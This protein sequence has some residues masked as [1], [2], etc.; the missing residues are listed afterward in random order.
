MLQRSREPSGSPGQGYPVTAERVLLE[1]LERGVQLW[2]EGDEVRFRAPKGAVDSEL[3]QA[4]Q[5]HKAEIVALL[6]QHRKHALCS[7][8]QRRLWFVD[9]LQPGAAAYNMP[10]PLKLSGRLDVAALAAARDRIAR[11]HESLRTSLGTVEGQPVQVI[12]L[13]CDDRPALPRVDL[14]G[15]RAADRSTEARRLASREAQ[16]PFELGRGPLWRTTLLHLADGEARH[17]RHVLLLTMHH[18]VS[19]GRSHEILQHEL[20]TFYRLFAGN[21]SE[22]TG[23]EA[24]LPELPVQY[25]DFAF[26]QRRQLSGEALE[27]HLDYWRRQLADLP[28]VELPADRPRQ[29]GWSPRGATDFFTLPAAGIE[30]LGRL[31]RE[32]KA[33]SF[34]TLLAVFLELLRRFTGQD[35]LVVGS[36]VANRGTRELEGLIGFFVNNL[37]LRLNLSSDRPG[38]TSRSPNFHDLLKRVRETALEAYSHQEL[39]FE[40]LVEELRPRRDPDRHPLFQI[41]FAAHEGVPESA[42]E[43]SGLTLEPSG[44]ETRTVRFDAE[45]N[46]WP[47]ASTG[48]WVY[49]ADLFDA[50]TIARLSRRLAVLLSAVATEPDRPLA[51][52]PWLPVAERHQLLV[53][54]N[55]TRTGTPSETP[56]HRLFERSALRRP[57]AVA[58]D[59][60]DLKLSYRELDR[61]AERLARRLLA[62]GVTAE[63]PVGLL[64]EPCAEMV[65][66]LLA[67]LEAGGA[68]LPLDPSYPEQRLRDM[69]EDAG[70]ELVL[71]RRGGPRAPAG[72]RGIDLD[73]ELEASGPAGPDRGNRRRD[74]D[75]GA[76][77]YVMYTSGSTGRPKGIGIPHRAIARLALDT[78]YV[79]LRD[80]DRVAQ[81]SNTSFDAATFEIWGA[82]STGACLTGIP[83]DAV[84]LPRRLVGELR[85]RRVSTLFLTT[86]LFN[87]VIREQPDGLRSLRHVLFGGEAVDPERV[88]QALESR[89]PRRSSRR[90]TG[91]RLLHVYGPTESTTFASWQRVRSVARGARGVPIGM[92]LSN[93]ELYVTASG[94]RPAPAG[95][96]GELCVGGDG[97]A[98]GYLGRP[99]KT[100]ASFVPDPFSRTPGGRLYRTGDRVCQTAA[101]AVD[102][103]GRFDHQLKIRGFRI[104]PG[105]I[106]MA[107]GRHPAVREALVLPSPAP[108]DNSSGAERRP[109]RLIAYVVPAGDG[110]APADELRAYLGRK[111]PAFMVPSAFVELPELPLTPGGKV[112]RAALARAAPLGEPE[113]SSAG[114]V[115]PSTPTEEILAG[116]FTQVLGVER[117]GVHDDFFQLGGHSLLATRV[118]SRLR[119]TFRAELP[120]RALFEKPTVAALATAVEH[121]SATP[122]PPLLPVA[123]DRALPLSF[124][125]QRLWFLHQL[126]SERSPYHMP[127]ALGLRGDLDTAALEA[128]FNAL[129][130]RHEALRTAFP[131]IAGRPRQVIASLRRRGLPIVDLSGLASP[132][133][134]T[135]SDRLATEE[136]VRPFDLARGPL[137]RFALLCHTENEHVLLLNLHHVISDGWSHGVLFDELSQ[138]YEAF[139]ERRPSP[140]PALPIQYADF[141]VWQR[142]WLSDGDGDDAEQSPLEAQLDYWRDQLAGAPFLRLPSDRPAPPVMSYRGAQR[143][144]ALSAE[145]T[146]ALRGLSGSSGATLFMTLM[147]AFMS[148][149]GRLTGLDDVVVG[150]P[151][152]NRNRR[153]IERLIG[154]FVNTLALRGDLSGN[155]SFRALLGRIRE[156][157]FSA[158]AHQDLPFEQLVEEL[159][160]E[161]DLSRNPLF[162]VAFMLQNA[163]A[164]DI[165]LAG[166]EVIPEMAPYDRTRYDLEVHLWEAG[167]ALDGFISYSTDLFDPTTMGRLWNHYRTLL[168]A[169]AEGADLS[170]ADLPLLPAAERQ[171]LL[172]EWNDNR[173]DDP[174]PFIFHRRFEARAERQG[175]AVALI[176]DHFVTYRQLDRRANRLA[177]YLRRLGIGPEVR[178]GL[179][180]ERSAE[181]VIALLAILKSGGAY[182]PLDP[183]YPRERL[184]FMLRDAGCA[185][186][187]TRRG[188]TPAEV[189]PSHVRV[190]CL[191]AI[192][193]GIAGESPERPPSAARADNLAYVIYTSG[194]TGLPKG[195][196]IRH[197]GLCHLVAEP[198]LANG[199]GDHVLQF[200]SL[201]FDAS[202]F[203]I[204]ATLGGGATLHLTVDPPAP[205]SPFLDLLRRRRVSKAVV[206]PS[207]LAA[208]P[209][210]TSRRLPA[211][212]CLLVAGEPC[213]VDLAERW[214]EGRRFLNGYGPTEATVCAT[215]GRLDLRRR[216]LPI[217]RANVNT[218][219]QVADSG[220]R[221]LPIATPG[222]LLIGGLGVGRGY[223][224][225]RALTAER[226]VP[227]PF[228]TSPGER[229]YR[230]GDLVHQL[231]DGHLDF[232]GRID[233]QVKVRGFRIELAE[234][235]AALTSH[236]L[237]REAAVVTR[238]D[239]AGDRRQLAA[240]VVQDC[241]A[242]SAELE[243]QDEWQREQVVGWR[244]LFDRAYVERAEDE[245]FNITGWDSS[246]TGR[247]IPAEEMR[248]WVDDTV[249]RLST[250]R[251]EG[252]APGRILE[253]GCGTGLLLH[254][255]APICNHYHGT[256][257]SAPGIAELERQ[258]AERS[259][260]LDHVELSVRLAEDFEGVPEAAYDLVILNSVAQYFSSADHLIEV[261]DGALARV[262]PGGCLFVGDVRSLPLLEAFHTSVE[263][264]KADPELPV[265]TLRQRVERGL[266][267]ENE[268]LLDPAFFEAFRRRHRSVRRLAVYPKSARSGNELTRFR[269]QV[270]LHLGIGDDGDDTANPATWLDWQSEGLTLDSVRRRL[271]ETA[272]AR[273]E[274]ARVPNARVAAAARAARVLRQAE[275]GVTAGDVLREAEPTAAGV[276]P[277]AL[278]ELAEEASY[279]AEL[280]WARHDDEGC[281]DL[282]LRRHD[283]EPAATA[284]PFPKPAAGRPWRDYA[285]DPLQGKFARRA[286]PELRRHLEERLPDFMIPAAFV[287]LE[288]MPHTPSGKVDRQ[289]LP[290]PEAVRPELLTSYLAPR[291][292]AEQTLTEIWSEV[293]G[294]ERVGVDDN[295]FE[296]GGHS[297]LGTQVISR[298]RRSFATQVPLKTLFERPT[299][300]ELAES[301]EAGGRR[302]AAPPLVPAPRD[303]DLPLSF[304]QQRLWFLDQLEP[305]TA[306]YN[307]PSAFHLAGDLDIAA[308]AAAL[309]EIARRHEVLRTAFPT[310]SGRPRQRITPRVPALLDTIDLTALPAETRRLETRRLAGRETRRPFDLARGPLLRAALLRLARREH[311][312]LLTMHHIISDGWSHGV[313]H[314]ELSALYAARGGPAAALPVLPIQYADFAVWQ[315]Q[316]LSGEVLAGELDYWR[317]QLDGLTTLQ[318]PSDRPRPAIPSYLGAAC[319]VRLDADLVGALRALATGAGASQFMTLLAGFMALLRRLSGQRDVVVGS[320]VANR[321]RAE[322]EPLIGF[323]VNTLVLRLPGSGAAGR[324]PDFRELLGQVRDVALAA[325]GHQH[326]SFEKLVEELQPERDLALHPL[327]QVTFDLHNAARDELEL[328][329]LVLSPIAM[330][331]GRARFDMEWNL[332]EEEGGG[333]TAACT[334]STELFDAT[335]AARMAGQFANLLR[336]IA[337]DPEL[338]PARAPLLS[339]AERHQLMAEW[340]DARVASPRASCLHRRFERQARATPDAVALVGWAGGEQLSYRRL[341]ARAE[342]LSRRLLALGAGPESRVALCAE[343]SPEM[344][345][346]LL[347]IW[348]AGAA[349]V[350][351]DPSHPAER[352]AFMLE[353]SGASI[354]LTDDS[355]SSLSAAYRP[356]TVRLDAEPSHDGTRGTSPGRAVAA[357]ATAD[358]L[359]YLIYTSG[360]TGK[361]KGVQITHRTLDNFLDSMARQPGFD[362]RDVLLAVTTLGFDISGLEIFLPLLA[363]GRVVLADRE[364]AAN[365]FRLRAAIAGAGATVMQA[366]PA[367]WQALIEAGWPGDRGLEVLCGGEALP[368]DLAAELRSRSAALWNMYGPTETT[369]WSMVYAGAAAGPGP[370]PIGRPIANTRVDLFDRRLGLVPAGVAG[371]LAIGGAGLARGYLGRAGLTAEQFVPDPASPEPGFRLYKT[372]DLAR[373]LGDGQVEFLGR[374]D[375]Q[376]KIRGFRIELGE[377]ESLLRA[378]PAVR[379]AVV[380]ARR[381]SGAAPSGPDQAAER[382]V[383]YFACDPVPGEA[384]APAAGRGRP[385]AA[386][387][388]TFLGQRLPEYMV[389]SA[390]VHLPALPRNPSGKVDRA[391]LPAPDPRRDETGSAYAAPR[392]PVEEAL[393]E[394]WSQVLGN[395]R[396]D[397]K[398][399]GG[400]EAARRIGVHD[401]FFELGGHSLL[402]TQVI[403]RIRRSFR[404]ELPLRRLFEGPTVAELA[405]SL[406]EAA[407]GDAALPP[408]PPIKPVTRDRALPLSF[409]QERLWFLDRLEPDRAAYNMPAAQRLTGDLD[410]PALEAALRELQRRHETL[411]TRFPTDGDRPRQQIE[412][413]AALELPL[414][415]LGA[416]PDAEGSDVAARLASR[417]AARPFDLAAGPLL[418]VLLLRLAP[419]QHVLFVNLHHVVSDGWSH[420]ILFHELAELYETFRSGGGAVASTLPEL[421]IQY[422]DYAVWQRRRLRGETLEA[423]LDYWLRRLGGASDGRGAAGRAPVLLLPADRPR[424]AIKTYRGAMTMRQLPESLNPALR[425]LGLTAGASLYMTLLS[426]FVTLLHRLTG[427]R[428]VA[429]GSP[430]AGRDAEELEGLIGFFVNTLV[431]RVDLSRNPVEGR[432]PTFRE[433]LERVRETALGAY[434]HQ[435]LPFEK[436]VE[437]LKPER[438]PAQSPL[439]QVMFVLQN[440]P[441][442]GP[443]SGGGPRAATPALEAS[444]FPFEGTTSIYDLTL[445]IQETGHGLFVLAR[446]NTDLFDPSTIR[447]FM[448]HYEALLTAAVTDPD[449][450][451]GALSLLPAAQRHQMLIE[452]NDTS[453][454]PVPGTVV[455][456]FE[457]RAA[458]APDAQA[459]VVD[460]DG[461]PPQ[462]LTYRQLDA[463]AGRLARDLRH[464]H[465][466]GRG[467]RVGLCVERSREMAVGLL[468]ILKSGAAYVPLDPSYPGERLAFMISET[469]GRVLLTQEALRA[470]LAPWIDGASTRVL[471]LDSEPSV[472]GPGPEPPGLEPPGPELPG[473]APSDLAYVIYTSGSTGRPKGIAM[474]HRG[475]ANLIAWRLEHLLTGK[476]TLQFASLSFDG[477]FPELFDTWCSGGTLFLVSEEGRRNMVALLRYLEESAIER[478][479]FPP[480]VLQHL[481]EEWRSAGLEEAPSLPLRELITSGEQLAVTPAIT[482]LLARHRE[483]AV[484]NHYGPSETHVVT[485]YPMPAE[486]ESWPQYPSI[487]RPIAGAVTHLLD[488]ALRPVAIGVAGEICIGGVGLAR[489][490]VDRPLLTAE[491]FVPD[492]IGPAPGGR[493]YRS[494]DEAR[495]LPGG[496]I[497]FLGRVDFQVK[498]R[499]FRIEP[500]EIET[501]LAEHPAVRHAAVVVRPASGAADRSLFAFVVPEP[502]VSGSRSVA[503]RDLRSFLREKIPAYMVPAVFIPVETLPLTPNRKVDRSELRRRARE[504]T[505]DTGRE[506][507]FVAPRSW[508]EKALAEIFSE[509]LDVERVGVR[510][511]FFAL[512]GHSLFAVRLT[513]RIEQSFGARLPVAALFQDATVEGLARAL[514]DLGSRTPSSL[515][516]IQPPLEPPASA[517]APFFC[518]HPGGGTVLCYH[519]LARH[520][521]EAQPFYALQARGLSGGEPFHE[522]LTTMAADYLAAIR[523]VRPHGPYALGGWSMGASV[524]Y[525]IACQLSGRGEDVGLLAMF[526]GAVP[527]PEIKVP[528]EQMLKYFAADLGLPADHPSLKW[529]ELARL[530]FEEAVARV[531]EQ[532]RLAGRLAPDQNLE[533]LQRYFRLFMH[534][535]EL[536]KEYQP[537]P[538]AGTIHMFRAEEG[539]T[540]G[541]RVWRF[542]HLGW[543]DLVEDVR[544]SVVSGNHTNMMEQPHVGSLAQQ[545]KPLLARVRP[546][547]SQAVADSA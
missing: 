153:E 310:R 515:V 473:P 492:P 450:G 154:F 119:S 49:N 497:E 218:R 407:R 170:L 88:R 327:F 33:S 92:P 418:R 505:G 434:A 110:G 516:A 235:E 61:R 28:G 467:D 185:A 287:L 501:L 172:A 507:A 82:L 340:N 342:R 362:A 136:A 370:L 183:D 537:S 207:F 18:A 536:I 100:A 304:A 181:M 35:D 27:S 324:D 94:G 332:W 1:L 543:R 439:F 367:T 406:A 391:A 440:A 351:L 307:M 87:Q 258:I 212:D 125:Q 269:Y 140:L 385:P 544:I 395:D 247:P 30:A 57:D 448:D 355:G 299:I 476:R 78:N 21:G 369:I 325:Y 282:V 234:I 40:K 174:G 189:A 521:G 461:A 202:T 150:S 368:A 389:P 478:A 106:E 508:V 188:L 510:D 47:G 308:L 315:R 19:D 531:F 419:D 149:L 264:H 382:L 4:F 538:Y 547:G 97:L 541:P 229:Q 206:P 6:G 256:D 415:D 143:F 162:Q 222:E 267:Q 196:M 41:T 285:N 337:A 25:A 42:T 477:S 410:R 224:A 453:I 403:S 249:G 179:A 216:K 493:L 394:I 191:D 195:A 39:P 503:P 168:D 498:I 217:G 442:R 262:A 225:R 338:C 529:Q 266:T 121:A 244:S 85:R 479:K 399:A 422:A 209:A 455:Q 449:R 117:V 517:A 336:A 164:S 108:G 361:P 223:L 12:A 115:A 228:G 102:F 167:E 480:A 233:H 53:A 293:L 380:S 99:A 16:Q 107:L 375:H 496:E 289:A 511:D 335:T 405:T 137:L 240:Y 311:A 349:Y 221:P 129:I 138:L 520:L 530:P 58:L 397:G 421:P 245:A 166:L 128:T 23:S 474:P 52:L 251:P 494:G 200:S 344:V 303:S 54:W 540:G 171:Q 456:W 141:A 190:V 500:E 271:S 358:N 356:R 123:R 169:I 430:I 159:Q 376:V 105:E 63:T 347:A 66:A 9:Q 46:L 302:Q 441:G 75:A 253:I 468:G 132:R 3:R 460:R 366:T 482:E 374:V 381:G 177:R 446:Y 8:A 62:L 68:Y 111:L 152:A 15:L 424:P 230:T 288:E 59:F 17:E 252:R 257:F 417:E 345:V 201:S 280:S 178:V 7:F 232:L 485:A 231:A 423:L 98:R 70:A 24:A 425:S 452:W 180:L 198:M 509:L 157:A 313:F 413:D 522:D 499:G 317:R 411:R 318:L 192:A 290:A 243:L 210:G 134:L 490:Y 396:P 65:V 133:R 495:H 151:I 426:A 454:A 319:G 339:A 203:E 29:N 312:L 50:T 365:A 373:R 84:L 163:P 469:R 350:P 379:E 45:L 26:W 348:K 383:A 73:D 322:L 346:A 432:D 402:A 539:L 436:L 22:P 512:G 74:D 254:R 387:L 60:D 272:P 294:I 214:A 283:V 334:Y 31:G 416:L 112:D 182:V 51:E 34:M 524:A 242:G 502:A 438:D 281:F 77:A 323:F 409:A 542:R 378:H 433:L 67:V 483:I 330:G 472:A 5:S 357:D 259:P 248:E 471:C 71:R 90:G 83:R 464:R 527:E 343:R 275:E 43:Q 93:T 534:N 227:D 331:S 462:R 139:V 353:D 10:A 377:I 36:P 329:G 393:V 525:E 457:E 145:T 360:S 292:A 109:A 101:G 328:P 118:I 465:G 326:L 127:S 286:V 278:L 147:A 273:L 341:D 305:G 451:L 32:H 390:F 491:R 297:M 160:P 76:L 173:R 20:L 199:P 211:L 91:G 364:V 186:V 306:A 155:P 193:E 237:V 279:L 447:R 533:D 13:T 274:L 38:H 11:R 69:A 466:V 130:A 95:V 532:G 238:E 526:D 371:E 205:E 158:Y 314:G 213:A 429:V 37:V 239:S 113:D 64:L 372:G 96:P 226:F 250:L 408:A 475:P 523:E 488:S 404:V 135:E 514:A 321:D 144:V 504:A 443:V 197:R 208:L 165:E 103:R 333:L 296:L 161:R 270:E 301:L 276:E 79:Q 506:E 470:R 398:P 261:L 241:E 56:V 458:A 291:T 463:A 435:E 104:E 120:A 545:L 2:A 481:A 486:A 546:A 219:I 263:L 284:F 81:L 414:V 295:F 401:N 352:L 124:A 518:V 320:A 484:H 513:T 126:E 519:N 142:R 445:S 220:L 400:G 268:L 48:G 55:D 176:S 14:T 386:E 363:G 431:L 215:V 384:G 309:E 156:T 459:L 175:D 359:A 444:P 86:A 489:G 535:Q 487:G 265:E 412:A 187:L 131:S 316:W 420:G 122:A 204:A 392:S 528:A 255:L 354:L 388:R 260:A 44:L 236:P 246:Y 300:A 148:L 277:A 298:V 80:D 114:Y 184:S 194:S 89:P 146:R 427:Q 116:I 428:D 72:T 437:E